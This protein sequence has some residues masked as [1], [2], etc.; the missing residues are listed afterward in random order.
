MNIG[1]PGQGGM[2]KCYLSPPT[3]TK[4]RREKEKKN[5]YFQ[6]HADEKKNIIRAQLTKTTVELGEW[7]RGKA[8]KERGK[9]KTSLYSWQKYRDLVSI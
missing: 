6:C 5:T 1:L 7:G 9:K 3:K 2:G 4:R 8:L